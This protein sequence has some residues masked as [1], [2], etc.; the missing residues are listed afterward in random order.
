MCKKNG[1]LYDIKMR[2]KCKVM[3]RMFMFLKILNFLYVFENVANWYVWDMTCVLVVTLKFSHA[4]PGILSSF[5]KQYLLISDIWPILPWRITT[6]KRLWVV[7]SHQM[8][9]AVRGMLAVAS[10]LGISH[11]PSSIKTAGGGRKEATD[12]VPPRLDLQSVRAS[13]RDDFARNYIE[14]HF[15]LWGYQGRRSSVYNV[16]I[17]LTSPQSVW[18]SCKVVNNNPPPLSVS[19]TA[20]DHNNLPRALLEL[21]NFHDFP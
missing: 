1:K 14:T 19:L 4:D 12:L 16:S 15:A 6:Y 3:D 20:S 13:L 17:I 5:S 21:R 7:P 2:L 18:L 11:V 10:C 8:I 9:K